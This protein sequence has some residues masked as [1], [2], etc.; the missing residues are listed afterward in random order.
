LLEKTVVSVSF[1]QGVDL[2]T[3]EKQIPAGKMALLENAQL[4]ETL[5]TIR[6][7]NGFAAIPGVGA[8][9]TE[10][11]ALATRGDELFIA[12]GSR[13]YALSSL[14][15]VDKGPCEALAISTKPV[16]RS[17]YQQTTPDCAIHSAG[18]SVFTWEDSSGG[19]RYSVHD[20][21]TG[22]PIVSNALLSATGEKPKPFALGNYVAIVY[23]EAATGHVA[24]VAIPVTAPSAPRDPVDI[25]TNSDASAMYDAAI[26]TDR[27]FVAYMN[28]G[29]TNRISL[30]YLTPHLTL[31]A[32]AVVSTDEA[33]ACLA[34]FG[35]EESNVWVAWG[36]VS[37][38]PVGGAFIRQ[39]TITAAAYSYGL[40]T[41]M[42]APAPVD[43]IQGGVRNIAGV[44]SG[45]SATV[46]YELD[47]AEPHDHQIRKVSVTLAGVAS[48]AAVLARSVGLASKPWIVN[49][50]VH[51]LAAHD[52]PLQPTYFVLAG[53]SVVGKIAPG[54]GGGITAKPILPEV[55][56]SGG[57]YSLAYLKAHRL[58]P[59]GGN[60]LA[61]TGVML[62]S[63][64]FAAAPLTLELSE[65][66]HVTGGVLWMFDGARVVEHG[67]H[68]FPENL[69]ATA[70]ETDG[71]VDAGQHQYVAVYEWTDNAGLVH[72]SAPSVPV[73]VTTTGST[74]SVALTIPTLRLTAK[75]SPV[76][77]AVYGTQAD[78]AI[79]Y[80]LTSLSS[81]LVNDST[82]D[83]VTFTVT[84]A[85]SAIVG[86]EQLYTTGGEVE[87]IAPP[88][89]LVVASYRNR[90]I[91]VPSEN[92]LSWWFS[93]KLLPG[94]PVEF[95]DSF[96]QAMD[97]RGGGITAAAS[98]DE[99]LILFKRSQV[100][101]VVGD[102][103]SANGLQ[104]DYSD[105]HQIPSDV[106][107]ISP[108]SLV[109]TPD[110]LMFQ[111]EKGIYLLD[112]SLAVQY[113]GDDVDA[114]RG[115]IVT[116]ARLLSDT[117]EVRFTLDN[118]IALVWNYLARQWSVSPSIDAADATIFQGRFT[119]L[120]PSGLVLQE[121]PGT[122]TDDGSLVRVKAKTAWFSFAGLQGF[123]RVYR[124]L[125]L[126]EYK[127][128]H[129]ITISIAYDFN[130]EPV[131]VVTVDAEDL[132]GTPLYGA[133]EAFGSGSPFGGEHPT[134]CFR[135]HLARQKCSA[136]QVMIEESQS[137]PYGEGLG[138]SALA[139]EVGAKRGSWKRPASR[140]VRG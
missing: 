102:G 99:K 129:K 101:V 119:Y 37:H 127:G 29:A 34:V 68:L 39:S 30:R 85:D 36:L 56:L 126:G 72:R 25:A 35:D 91:L 23:F 59:S 51:V 110:G 49:D 47:A 61:Q 134:Y 73:T 103:P 132:L 70:S 2:S 97:Q 19:A 67:F 12:S 98:M 138:L 27:L 26:V 52:S 11:R 94:A 14:G 135:L 60:I 6:K 122:Y 53:A 81:P 20:A 74:A 50:E 75:S 31:S 113:V 40:T 69:T 118:G 63:L 38:L 115:S 116:A 55:V 21:A 71:T 43:V 77:I 125:L 95:S 66:L 57:T 79:F 114:Y 44:V 82:A 54:D 5:K 133:D 7:R 80:R 128:P 1:G 41:G 108:R 24:Y 123:Q 16:L 120:R 89:P 105:P 86:N 62:A 48:G 13:G 10:G 137:P 92:P 109:L 84:Q 131:Q 83:S 136:V 121:T 15:Y 106:G 9:V 46:L 139:F 87:N 93:K 28:T 32:E 117:H 3:D 17:T 78:Q 8:T 33:P 140:T 90:A 130:P 45:D 107:C 64:D 65:N 111:S 88:A 18:I 58:D 22:Q 124:L 112:R 4:S 100:F 104:N 76:S 96:V 42:L